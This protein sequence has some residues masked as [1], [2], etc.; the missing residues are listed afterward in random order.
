M[1]GLS[2]IVTGITIASLCV[3]P[4]RIAAQNANVYYSHKPSSDTAANPRLTYLLS[5]ERTGNGPGDRHVGQPPRLEVP[6]GSKTC[7]EIEDSNPL[8]YTYEVQSKTI[9]VQTPEGYSALLA[10]L[11]AVVGAPAGGVAKAEASATRA[12]LLRGEQA[13]P[14]LQS[15]IVSNDSI[16]IDDYKL[17][18]NLIAAAATRLDSLRQASDNSFI[19]YDA[20]DAAKSDAEKWTRVA[21]S[22]FKEYPTTLGVQLRRPLQL[23]AAKAV[24][25]AYKPFSD[26]RALGAPQYCADIKDSPVHV[27]LKAT[28]KVPSEQHPRPIG[29]IVQVDVEPVND[30]QFEILPVGII[31]FAVPGAKTFYLDANKKV[32]ERPD[33]GG[34]FPSAGALASFRLTRL[35]WVGAAAAKGQSSTPDSFVG[36]L[37]RNPS[38]ARFFVLGVGAGFASVPT[39]LQGGAT[40]NGDLPPGADLS[41][42]IKKSVHVG[43]SLVVAMT[44]LSLSK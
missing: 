30:K 34:Y 13:R 32:Q 7:F 22:I 6:V 8:L 10:A 31:T 21:D 44:G 9:T 23:E 12:G 2:P 4:H 25:A 18:I 37:F 14:T 26:A 24:I 20:A 39:D 19:N 15:T 40:I 3:L 35:V 1:K 33:K 42:V 17:A 27:T 43:L 29:E 11:A 38:I 36:F 41:K 16:A 28:R 5:G